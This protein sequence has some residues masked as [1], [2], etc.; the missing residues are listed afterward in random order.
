MTKKELKILLALNGNQR[1]V[2]L[3]DEIFS[4]SDYVIVHYVKCAI[5]YSTFT[6]AGV[7]G[8]EYIKIKDVPH[9]LFYFSRRVIKGRWIAAETIFDRF[10]KDSW[11]TCYNRYCRLDI[12]LAP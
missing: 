10:N 6:G 1:L 9:I 8:P 3:E 4:S 11:S 5:Y 12:Y 2:H 7:I